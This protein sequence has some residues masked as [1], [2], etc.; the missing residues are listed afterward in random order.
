MLDT[1]ACYCLI[2]ISVFCILP[3]AGQPGSAVHNIEMFIKHLNMTVA[4]LAWNTAISFSIFLISM[5][6]QTQTEP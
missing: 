6:G 3:G 4:P 1:E 2:E 5:T